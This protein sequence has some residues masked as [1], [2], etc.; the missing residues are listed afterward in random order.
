[1]AA[2]DWLK[3]ISWPCTALARHEKENATCDGPD[4]LFIVS[5]IACRLSCRSIWSAPSYRMEFV[6]Y[7]SDRRL[8]RADSF[9]GSD[10]F[11]HRV[12]GAPVQPFMKEG[13][14]ELMT[15]FDPRR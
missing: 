2:V 8:G 3:N 13:W 11:L 10:F 12:F 7:V 15:R 4:R 9:C 6:D 14:E 5:W 1:M